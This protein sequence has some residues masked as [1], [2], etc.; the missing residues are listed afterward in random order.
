M[1]KR[2]KPVSHRLNVQLLVEE[3]SVLITQDRN[4]AAPVQ[5]QFTFD[6]VFG[7]GASQAELYA[8]RPFPVGCRPAACRRARPSDL[9]AD[10]HR[11]ASSPGYSM[12]IRALGVVGGVGEQRDPGRSR[13]GTRPSRRLLLT[14]L[15]TVSTRRCS[16]MGRQAPGKRSPHLLTPRTLH[17]DWGTSAAGIGAHPRVL[18]GQHVAQ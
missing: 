14:M 17:P 12:P 2:T 9:G 15:S 10:G 1:R 6:K 3:G 7:P 18:F 8:H 11:C 5:H 16:L 4:D 13:A